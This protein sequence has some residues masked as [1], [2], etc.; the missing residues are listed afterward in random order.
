MLTKTEAITIGAFLASLEGSN[1]PI[2]RPS[3][4]EPSFWSRPIFVTRSRPI[5]ANTDWADY[6]VV[7]GLKQ[8]IAVVTHYA[9]TS[10]GDFALSGLEFRYRLDGSILPL[11]A[12]DLTPGIERNKT[13]P[14]V[15]PVIPRKLYQPVLETERLVLQVRNP[16]GIQRVA[17]GAMYG[18]YFDSIDSTMFSGAESGIADAIYAGNTGA[19]Y[20]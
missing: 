3:Y 18:W 17:V 4:T 20:V 8:Y 15:Y 19:P 16:T 9:A 1:L 11:G 7:T 12:V 10:V 5:P 6:L 13:G 2:R 14:M